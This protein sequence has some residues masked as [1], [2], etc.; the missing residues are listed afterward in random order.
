MPHS[1]R[2]DIEQLKKDFGDVVNTVDIN[3]IP[4]DLFSMLGLTDADQTAPT[5]SEAEGTGSANQLSVDAYSNNKDYTLIINTHGD[6][7]HTMISKNY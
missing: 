5:N 7:L 4:L 3:P 6:V 1:T 2:L